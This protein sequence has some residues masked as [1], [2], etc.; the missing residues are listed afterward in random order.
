MSVLNE[1]SG[2]RYTFVYLLLSIVV[3]TAL[4]GLIVDVEQAK[5]VRA[6][7][8]EA[9]ITLQDEA[10]HGKEMPMRADSVRLVGTNVDGER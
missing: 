2:L 6:R 9:Q 3:P 4:L 5:R 10:A 8:T 7:P 1:T